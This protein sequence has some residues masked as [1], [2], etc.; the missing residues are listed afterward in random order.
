MKMV[1][2]VKYRLNNFC[3][4]FID[5]IAFTYIFLVTGILVLA[6]CY[7]N[8]EFNERSAFYFS[9]ESRKNSS[10][11]NKLIKNLPLPLVVLDEKLEPK[12]WNNMMENIK[13]KLDASA[14]LA[15]ITRNDVNSLAYSIN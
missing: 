2:N 12:F 11:T 1:L 13:P 15:L 4:F 8:S 14:S 5:A 9:L 7:Y 3:L 10:S 6:A